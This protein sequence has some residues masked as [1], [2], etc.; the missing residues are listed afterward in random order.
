MEAT[1]PLAHQNNPPVQVSA[2]S[3]PQLPKAAVTAPRIVTKTRVVR[4]SPPF[5][6]SFQC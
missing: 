5:S 1:V 2:P 4:L 3:P 6:P